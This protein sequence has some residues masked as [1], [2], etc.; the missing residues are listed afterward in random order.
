MDRES[1]MKYV[2]KLKDYVTDELLIEKGFLIE[3]S[4]NFTW[5]I[6]RVTELPKNNNEPR[7]TIL[8]KLDPPERKI[9]FRYTKDDDDYDLLQEIDFM[10]DLFKVTFR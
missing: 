9:V 2:V 8:I 4:K 7:G 5:A 1:N 6:K 10:R 3:Q